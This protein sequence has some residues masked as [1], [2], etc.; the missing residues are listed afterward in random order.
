MTRFVPVISDNACYVPWEDRL[1][2]EDCETK[3]GI[4]VYVGRVIRNTAFDPS[5]FRSMGISDAPMVDMGRMMQCTK[6]EILA[7]MANDGAIGCM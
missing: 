2:E 6:I 3:V 7:E 4:P 1:Y 5:K